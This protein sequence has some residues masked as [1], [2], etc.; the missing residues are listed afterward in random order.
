MVWLFGIGYLS[1]NIWFSSDF[2]EQGFLI[3]D[4]MSTNSGTFLWRYA[5]IH[6][7]NE[8][9]IILNRFLLITVSSF[10]N[11]L[12]SVDVFSFFLWNNA[13]FKKW[14]DV[15]RCRLTSRLTLFFLCYCWFLMF[16]YCFHDWKAKR[17]IRK[18]LFL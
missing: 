10:K 17:L 3:F 4:F 11:D 8:L 18:C 5:G 7:K 9:K 15:G 13:G 2:N 12:L 1:L 16:K 6:N 14:Q